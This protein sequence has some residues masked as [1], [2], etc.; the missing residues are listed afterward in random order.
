[1]Y[2]KYNPSPGFLAP[3]DKKAL[4]NDSVVVPKCDTNMLKADYG[5]YV[6][7][8]QSANPSIV[9]TRELADK[10]IEAALQPTLNC[11]R[12]VRYTEVRTQI[13]PEDL[14]RRVGFSGASQ[15]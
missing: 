14:R 15:K 11:K 13:R 3:S 2:Q 7:K 10:A 12:H 4:L 5:H 8:I 9:L 1:M 6:Q